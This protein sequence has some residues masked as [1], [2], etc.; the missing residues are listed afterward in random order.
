LWWFLIKYFYM[1]LAATKNTSLSRSLLAGLVCG[2]I[3]AFLNAGYNFFY[4]KAADLTSYKVIEPLLIFFAF[5]LL[6]LIVGIIFFE[7]VE[8]I[9]NGRLL[10]TILFLVLMLV[11]I[12]LDI[13]QL[14]KAI[15]GLLLG[16]ILITGLL[17]SLLLPFLA[18]HPKIFMDQEEFSESAES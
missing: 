11:G 3:A 13:S 12:I 16:I 15:E 6:F 5:P 2:L 17:I 14:G 10:F 1:H 8:N 18:T 7:M 9:K 4:R